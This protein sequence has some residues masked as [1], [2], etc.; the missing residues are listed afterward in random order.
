MIIKEKNVLTWKEKLTEK[1]SANGTLNN[2]NFL[3]KLE[4]N[5]HINTNTHTRMYSIINP[6]YHCFPNEY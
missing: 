4:L 5:T 2:R 1:W 3:M 6:P